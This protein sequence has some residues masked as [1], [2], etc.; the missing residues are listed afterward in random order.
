MLAN[1]LKDKHSCFHCG[2]PCITDVVV[3]EKHF[4]CTGCSQVFLLL[5]ENNLCTYYDLDKTP[6]LTAKGKF[7]SERFAYLDDVSVIDKLVSFRSDEQVNIL[8]R[9]PQM[10]CASCIYLLENL[11]K[12][13]EAVIKS[14]VHF[15]KKE[16][17]VS[18]NP[19]GNSL[20]KLVELLAFI[21]YEPAISLED[22]AAITKNKFNKGRV[23]ELGV[24]GFCFSNIMMLSFPE[25][26]SG[27]DIEPGLKQT[28]TWVIFALSLPVIFFSARSIF[29]SAWK[30]LRQGIV[31]IDA[32]IALASVITFGRSYY[33][34]ISGTGAGYLDSGAG[35]IFFMLIGR[36]FQSKTYD[37]LSFDRQYK[38]YFPLGVTV[39]KNS[40]EENI[41]VTKLKVG[42]TIVVRNE[43]MIPADAVLL[44]GKANI[45][46]SF[47]T[48]EHKPVE[49]KLNDVLF[50]GGKQM[51]GR[52]QLL[53]QK[54]P[55]QSYITQLWNNDIFTSE[56]NS[57]KHSKESF[58]HPW[59]RYFTI[60]LFSIAA[61]TGIYWSINAPEKTWYA[62]TAV[63]IVACPCSLL[64][65]STF[66]FGSMQRIFGK[67]KL[68]LKNASVIESL[69]A[70][71][72]IVFDKT[73]TLTQRLAF[74][75]GFVGTPLNAEEEMQ[76]YGATTHSSHILSKAI[77]NSLLV[78]EKAATSYFK[79]FS[80]LGIDAVVNNTDIKI[81]SSV[82]LGQS[83]SNENTMAS[84]RVHVQINNQYKG[85]Y[86][87]PG[88]YRKGL[89]AMTHQLGHNG[90]GLH[91]LSGDNN[92]EEANMRSIFGKDAT[93][94]F[95]QSPEQKL[96]YIKNC[97]ESSGKVLMIGD[98][99]NDAG[100][101]MQANCGIA[102]S[103]DAGR[104]SPA[105]DA[106]IDGSMIPELPKLL[107]Y[108]KWGKKI[109][110]A[111]FILSILY[112]FVGLS[113][114][115]QGKLS[116]LVAAILMPLSSISIV[117][118]AGLLSGIV[119][120]RIGLSTKTDESHV[121]I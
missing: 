92:A 56:T 67:N 83:E 96:N 100:A 117:S 66:S 119:A 33:E 41:P 42:D 49:K 99:L 54:E 113:F 93:I 5:N 12:I 105:C 38:S 107:A 106:I 15:E 14:Q 36:W 90:Y 48:G 53:V 58:I 30:G 114:A 24:A 94:L 1:T 111:G 37:A 85:Y 78:N 39:L 73:G 82:F 51:G 64:L 62:V 20:R 89:H 112:N 101:L 7:V 46:Y 103:D 95:N 70:I 21:G 13:N 26:F 72:Q 87:I 120:R 31:N 116:P 40:K 74:K 35:I 28:F 97:K 23:I 88:N 4:C 61:I 71:T 22:D 29:I 9:L 81:G 44:E 16:L 69:A 109:V 80:G 10:H 104:F 19:S 34:I 47:V 59:S 25:Y 57:L 79:E 45:D 108:A 75:P 50:A 65:S 84:S 102:V 3:N 32:P 77:S 60:V 17:F 98:G 8:F 68:Y 18:Y 91:L 121:F 27:G 6:G 76:V 110:L 2:E 115:V 118:L 43:E 11:H 63:L 86:E 55:S 52:I